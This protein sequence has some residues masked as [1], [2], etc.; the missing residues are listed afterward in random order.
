MP[1]RNRPASPLRTVF[2]QRLREARLAQGMTIADLAYAS[3][4]DWSYVTQVE[5]GRKNASLDVMDALA[6]ALNIPLGT[7]LLEEPEV[8]EADGD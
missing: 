2:G 4:V 3:Q 6:R 5:H 7:L 1:I 8:G